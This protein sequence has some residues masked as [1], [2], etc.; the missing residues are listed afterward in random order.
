MAFHSALQVQRWFPNHGVILTG[1]P[2][3]L[4]LKCPS[5]AGHASRQPRP[6]GDHL[7]QMALGALKLPVDY[8]RFPPIF[9]RRT[10]PWTNKSEGHL[11]VTK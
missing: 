6:A 10:L 7:L 5:W 11:A 2:G 3:Q 4:V 1:I 8:L 9:I